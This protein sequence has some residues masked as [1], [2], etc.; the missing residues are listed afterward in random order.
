VGGNV[1]VIDIGMTNKKVS[2]YGRDLRPLGS[3]SRSFS[4]LL[5]E[6]IE[7]HDLASI[8]QWILGSLAELGRSFEIG[9][10]AIATH[11]ATMVC[12]GEDGAPCAPCLYYTHEPGEAFQERF[13]ALAGGREELQE[14]TGTPPLSAMINPSKGLLFLRERFPEAY[15]R[16]RLA[17]G[18]PQYWVYRLTGAAGAEGTY[19]GCHNYLWDWRAGRYSSVA[20]A[21]GVAGKMPFPLRDSWAVAGALR[22]EVAERT[23]LG[24]GVAVTLGLHDSNASLLPHLAARKGGDFVLNSTGTWCVL[25]HPQ[26]EY[27]FAPDELG[28]VVFFNRSAYN[29]PVK[30]AIF[31]GGMEFGAWTGAFRR[32]LGLAEGAE[33]P[34][35]SA[36]DYRRV[37]E[38]RDLFVLPEL[39]PG[40]G[41]FPGSI[42]RARSAGADYAL[43]DIQSG[44]AVPA[45]LRDP[46]ASIAALNLSLA[47]QTRVAAER[48]GAGGGSDL[49]TEGGFRRNPGYNGL[50]AT[51]LRGRAYLTDIAEATSLGAAMTA[52]AALEGTAPDELAGRLDVAYARAAPIEGLGGLGAYGAAWLEL[53]KEGK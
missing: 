6:G 30:T 12:V 51:A 2:V 23:G 20:E 32:A 10:I 34:E 29:K 50:L 19:V 27:R 53:T 25:M 37:V 4:P 46:A 16:T 8:E 14:R 21:L 42:A 17:L 7:A 15:A 41:Q 31:L 47:L 24:T 22:P 39:V 49:I 43:A 36:A 9:A 5:V 35:P 40:S 18:Y 1:A 33:L 52:V 38:G 44:A 13:Y 11:G 45:F 28:K 3:T 26:E 48:A